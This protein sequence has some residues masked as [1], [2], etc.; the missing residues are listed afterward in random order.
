MADL[1]GL[2]ILA[3]HLLL[4][5]LVVLTFWALTL[6]RPI[7]WAVSYKHKRTL[8][9]ARQE[10]DLHLAKRQLYS[11]ASVDLQSLEQCL[12]WDFFK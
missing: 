1:P 7:S 2:L 6:A 4:E 9:M 8:S 10:L 5:Q 12:K 11:K 3:R